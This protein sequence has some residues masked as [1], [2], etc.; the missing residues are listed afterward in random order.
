MIKASMSISKGK[1]SINHNKRVFTADN[2]DGSRTHLNR[3]IIDENIQKVYD[4]LFSVALTKYN[5]KQKR[6]DRQIKNYYNHIAHSKQEK[7]FYELIVQ[8]GNINSL[9]D[10]YATYEKVLEEFVKNCQQKYPN[11]YIFGAYIHND[12]ATP[13]L[14][15]DYIPIAYN[16]KRGLET[17]NSHN[18][19]MKS[20]G[21]N[22]YRD[23]RQDLMK[24]LEKI[25]SKYDIERQELNDTNKHLSVRQYKETIKLA[26]RELA[27]K[28]PIKIKTK[29]ILTKEYVEKQT[30]EALEHQNMLLKA[31]NS[32]F[33]KENDILDRK[34][35]GMKKTTYFKENEYLKAKLEDYDSKISQITFQQAKIK[36]LSA[37]NSLLK[38]QNFEKENELSG[39][40]NFLNS[41]GLIEI[42][43][44]Y[45]H[46]SK[47]QDLIS[48]CRKVIETVQK[49]IKQLSATERIALPE[50]DIEIE[51]YDREHNRKSII[52]VH[53]YADAINVVDLLVHENHSS[54]ELVKNKVNE[55]LY[56]DVLNRNEKEYED[57]E[58]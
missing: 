57:F 42:F 37:E 50:D 44:T 26:E 27:K 22:D 19:A 2:V 39:V 36:E 24:T 38:R 28:E 29:K 17:R 51:V 1:G 12:E 55:F 31:Q 8:L 47:L 15:L 16:Q 20:M 56:E 25:A 49:K 43:K 41:L 10:M 52:T 30:F 7:P 21:F 13:H 9:S 18:L 32:S 40:Y 4:K 3:I 5:A 58:L 14:H 46:S 45:V 11:L 33:K 53:T 34:I 6:K 35:E 54:Y 48:N 23:F